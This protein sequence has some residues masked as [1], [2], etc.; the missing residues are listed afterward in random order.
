M[1]KL[2]LTILTSNLSPNPHSRETSIHPTSNTTIHPKQQNPNNNT[3]Y[4]NPP[5]GIQVLNERQK[6]CSWR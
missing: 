2:L 1:L 5:S 4:P 6:R 3:K